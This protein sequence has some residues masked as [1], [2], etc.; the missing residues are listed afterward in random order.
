MS[1]EPVMNAKPAAVAAE[2]IVKVQNLVKH[3]GIKRGVIVSKT[4]G[5]V[6][7]VDDVSF[8]IKRG[9]TLA[10]VGESGCGKSTTGR[11]ILRLLDP[12]TGSIEFKG[13]DIAGVDKHTMRHMRRHMQIIFQDP[14]ASLNPRMT[15]GEIIAEPMTVHG[16][17]EG[18]ARDDRVRELLQVVGLA[19]E[20]ASRYSHQF[21]GGQRQ[22]IGIAR[23]LAVNP[24]LIICDEPVSALD[25]S[26]QAQVVN[27]LQNLQQRFG[28]SY[29]FIAHDLAVVKHIS[30]RVAVM[31]L[32]KLVE[33]ADKR[34]STPSRRIPIRRRCCRRSRGPIR[35]SS[36]TA[37]CCR[38][39]CRA[40]SIRRRAA[41]S[42]PAAPLSRIAA[43][44]RS[45]SCARPAPAIVSPAISSRASPFRPESRRAMLL[46]SSPSGWRPSRRRRSATW[47]GGWRAEFV[48]PRDAAWATDRMAWPG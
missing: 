15:V 12:T 3:F 16:I 26:I 28:L 8:E 14:Y 17:A 45:R 40:R 31:Y 4:V 43:R 20:H 1:A 48:V 11:L 25:V 9:E 47:R 21:S 33:I 42:T 41:A 38:A 27:L 30:D 6:R 2:P 37:S 46:A 7:A 34:R 24:D 5:L 23:A 18:K 19:P 44:S 36:A 29:L 13:K 39:T 32:G 10:L 22:R 35:L